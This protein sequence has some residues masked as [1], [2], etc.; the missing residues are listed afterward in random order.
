MTPVS[1][2][3][4]ILAALLGLAALAATIG[5]IS[6]RAR[7]ALLESMAHTHVRGGP[8]G[9]AALAPRSARLHVANAG[10][11]RHPWSATEVDQ[12]TAEFFRAMVMWGWDKD[13]AEA[14][15]RRNM[16][17]ITLEPY[18]PGL[19]FKDAVAFKGSRL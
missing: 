13:L 14:F 19:A 5:T 17:W 1:W 7:V 8:A 4:L 18:K 9:E 15:V 12:Y 10:R 3:L 11:F 2:A 16:L 6:L